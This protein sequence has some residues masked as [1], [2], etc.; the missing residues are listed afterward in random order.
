MGSSRREDFDFGMSSDDNMPS[1]SDVL[2][3]EDTISKEEEEELGVPATPEKRPCPECGKKLTWLADNSRPR[4]HK[5]VP[6]VTAAGPILEV[7]KALNAAFAEDTKEIS[8]AIDEAALSP[9]AQP[10]SVNANLVIEKFVETRDLIAEKTKALKAEL[11]DMNDIQEKRIAWLQ[12]E[13]TRL[14]IESFKGAAGTAYEVVKD[15][16]TVADRDTFFV[17]VHAEW[18]TRKEFLENR[19]SKTAVKQRLEDGEV[20]PPGV[21]YSKLK[22]VQIRRS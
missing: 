4:A 10:V 8:A 22:T 13:L 14:G 7:A 17:W 19:I 18:E 21:N 2:F 20:L 15:S 16:A 9:V 11:A 6:A 12:G 1:D 5:C 3:D